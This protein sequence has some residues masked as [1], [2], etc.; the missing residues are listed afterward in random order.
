MKP[1]KDLLAE[2]PNIQ[3]TLVIGQ[4]AQA[5]HFSA[6]RPRSVTDMV[7]AWREGWPTR[8]ALP[9]PSPRNNR[10]LTRNPWFLKEV[11]PFLRAR[12]ADLVGSP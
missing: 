9:H 8:L 6:Q 10:W 11:V 4:Y 12:V 1:A 3:V 2:L 5:W 7:A